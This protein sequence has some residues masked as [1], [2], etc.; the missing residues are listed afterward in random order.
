MT[1]GVHSCHIALGKA[2]GVPRGGVETP[3]PLNRQNFF[4]IVFAKYTV[5]A[6]L[7]YSL[8][9]KFSTENVK[10]CT[11]ISHFASASGGLRPGPLPGLC[12]WTPLGYLRPPD[13]LA[14]PNAVNPVHFKILGT[15]G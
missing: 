14:M 1:S 7:L 13:R 12:P 9:P 3:P 8:K 15:P 11:L 4:L 6:L 2:T 5:Q 10:S